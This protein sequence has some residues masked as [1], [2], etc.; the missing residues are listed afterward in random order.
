MSNEEDVWQQWPLSVVNPKP[1]EAVGAQLQVG[2]A[3]P[4]ELEDAIRECSANQMPV[5]IVWIAPSYV[6]LERVEPVT[7]EEEKADIEATGFPWEFGVHQYFDVIPTIEVTGWS[8]D[9]AEAWYETLRCA[10]TEMALQHFEKMTDLP[11]FV[12]DCISNKFPS[13]VL[14]SVGGISWAHTKQN[15]EAVMAWSA[16]DFAGLMYSTMLSVDSPNTAKH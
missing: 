16:Q 9:E 5:S 13:S 14:F 8:D 7:D 2:A 1:P 11:L 4:Q 10:A 12:D 3:L 6:V 15:R